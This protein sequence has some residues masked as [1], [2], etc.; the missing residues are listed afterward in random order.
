MTDSA[1]E[2]LS[3]ETVKLVFYLLIVSCFWGLSIFITKPEIFKETL[4]VQVFVLF[5]VSFVWCFTGGIIGIL[6]ESTLLKM[7]LLKS[8]TLYHIRVEIYLALS[9]LLKCVLIFFAYYYS[10]KF[11]EYLYF[12][13][14]CSI[15]IILCLF[16]VFLMVRLAKSK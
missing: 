10:L 4:L 16:L 6:I 2:K 14:K 11:T 3:K 13:F 1:I 15:I 5:C 12:V 9:I 7:H 8:N